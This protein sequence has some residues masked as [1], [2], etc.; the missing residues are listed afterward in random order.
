MKMNRIIL[1]LIYS[2]MVVSPSIFCEDHVDPNSDSRVK[3]MAAYEKRSDGGMSFY[4]V[5]I[6]LLGNIIYYRYFDIDTSKHSFMRIG[7]QYVAYTSIKI[8]SNPNDGIDF[9]FISCTAGSSLTV[10]GRD[11]NLKD[12]FSLP[13]GISIGKD[14]VSY[15]ANIELENISKLSMNEKTVDPVWMN[16][17]EL[18]KF[19]VTR[20]VVP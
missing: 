7:Q 13:K 10:I 15:F 14:G 18:G 6:D 16:P 9:Y 19:D 5:A 11:G 8:V 4:A 3:V 20:S 2:T 1:F 12:I 17:N